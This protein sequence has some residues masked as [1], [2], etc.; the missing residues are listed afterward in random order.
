MTPREK[1]VEL[2]RTLYQVR[3]NAGS[4]ITKFFAKQSALIVVKEIIKSRKEDLNFDDTLISTG[5]EYYTPHPMYL[6][7]W[8]LVKEEIEKI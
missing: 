4:D 8:N 7:Y 2:F 1:A 3:S 6:T 5:S